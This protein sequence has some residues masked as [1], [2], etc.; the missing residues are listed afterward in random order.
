MNDHLKNIIRQSLT[1]KSS[2]KVNPWAVCHA[3]TGPEKTNKFERCVK[4]VKKKEGIS[5]DAVKN[6]RI[7]LAE[8]IFARS[9]SGR[10]LTRVA[11]GFGGTVAGAAEHNR[12]AALDRQTPDAMRHGKRSDFPHQQDAERD[13]A[14]RAAGG[15]VTYTFPRTKGP[16]PPT[17]PDGAPKPPGKDPRGPG[18]PGHGTGGHSFLALQRAMGRTDAP[19]SAGGSVGGSRLATPTRRGGGNVSRIRQ[20][21]AMDR[22]YRRGDASTEIVR[23]A[24][25][26]L[27]EKALSALSEEHG[28][29]TVTTIRGTSSGPKGHS[30]KSAMGHTKAGMFTK[31]GEPAKNPKSQA[32]NVD[33][34]QRTGQMSIEKINQSGVGGKRGAELSMALKSHRMKSPL[35][36]SKKK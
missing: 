18:L 7:D 25:M 23:G 20:D 26:A 22:M 5:E 36:P 17:T 28:K 12:Q 14:E 13:A 3:S 21:R 1:E 10:A 8:T 24:R 6:A 4:K 31:S 34:T 2:G 11:R 33:A 15:K 27:A 35:P 19:D 29:A 30:R 16:K 9:K 32:A